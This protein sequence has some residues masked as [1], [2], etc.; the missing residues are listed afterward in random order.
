MY[1]NKQ[2]HTLNNNKHKYTDG[3]LDDG[4]YIEKD[5]IDIDSVLASKCLY[6]LCEQH[7]RILFSKFRHQQYKQLHMFSSNIISRLA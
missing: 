5:G 4:L 7:V 2:N 6:V 1:I 3:M